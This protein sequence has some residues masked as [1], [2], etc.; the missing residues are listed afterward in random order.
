MSIVLGSFHSSFIIS[1][2][3]LPYNYFLNMILFFLTLFFSIYQFF[4]Q[5]FYSSSAISFTSLPYNY[6]HFVSFLYPIFPRAI[7]FLIWLP[8]S[9]IHY[10]S[11]SFASYLISPLSLYPSLSSFP[12][13][14]SSFSHFS[15][16]HPIWFIII[17]FAF[18]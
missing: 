18:L 13:C 8:S 16:L 7:F 14:S 15:P 10:L 11:P 2:T 12:P 3:S 4:F 6:L 9:F 1:F 5:Y 17:C